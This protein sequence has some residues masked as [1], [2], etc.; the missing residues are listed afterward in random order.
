MRTW[1][2]GGNDGA[3]KGFG[4]VGMLCGEVQVLS[5]LNS[6]SSRID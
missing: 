6:S 2:S 5:S 1:D 4:G 3:Y